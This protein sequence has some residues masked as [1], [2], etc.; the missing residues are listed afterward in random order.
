MVPRQNLA[1]D[2]RAWML[3]DHAGLAERFDQSIGRIVPPARWREQ[4]D[5]GGSSIAWLLLHTALHEDLAVSTAVRGTPPHRV[6]WQGDLGLLSFPAHAGLGEAEDVAVTGA[7]DLD[8]LVAFGGAVHR[9]VDEWL[10]SVEPAALDDV[11]PASTRIEELAGVTTAAVPWLHA[12]WQ[13]KP[14]DWFVRWESIGH[15]QGHLGEMISVR[16]RLGLSPF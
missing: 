5:G 13:D 3:A 14:V 12:M 9:D 15:R 7:V 4:A 2:L 11:P 6:R 1:V 10:S 16:N 8:A